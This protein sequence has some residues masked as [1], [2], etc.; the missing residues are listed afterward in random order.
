MLCRAVLQAVVFGR[1][2]TTLGTF[3]HCARLTPDAD[4]L[5]MVVLQLLLVRP[6]PPGPLVPRS[7]CE[8]AASG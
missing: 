8:R 5:C 1:L 4:R 6:P 2:L 3:C 7:L